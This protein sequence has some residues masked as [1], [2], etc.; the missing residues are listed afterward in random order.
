MAIPASSVDTSYNLTGYRAMPAS[1]WIF[2]HFVTIP[3]M[4]NNQY[5]VEVQGFNNDTHIDKVY[6]ETGTKIRVFGPNAFANMSN[7]TYIDFPSSLRQICDNACKQSPLSE[8]TYF[9]GENTTVL[10]VLAFNGG[11]EN[12]SATTLY[13]PSSVCVMCRGCLSNQ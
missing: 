3:A 12:S 10:G 9:G 1:G 4:Y 13:V 8:L 5:I 6:F 7:L 11:I 2:E